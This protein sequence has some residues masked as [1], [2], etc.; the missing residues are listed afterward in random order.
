MNKDRPPELRS[1]R[2]RILT[3]LVHGYFSLSRGMTV[4]VR[5]ACFDDRG[6]IFL[7][8]H[9][10]VPG[11]YMPGGGVERFETAEQALEKELKEE[12]NLEITG[13]PQLFHVYYN[14]K[15]SKRDHVLFYKVAVHQTAPRLPDRE[16]VESGFFDPDRLPPG[17]TAATRRRLDELRGTAEPDAYW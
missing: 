14:R 2:A 7:V 13:R 16:I 5:A 15:V 10:Y 3:R 17:T 8:R 6:R 12:G 9:G 4:G 11:W 1:L